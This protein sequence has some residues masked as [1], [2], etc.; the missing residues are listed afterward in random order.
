ML[1]TED[2]E[3]YP[4]I[5]TFEYD[6]EAREMVIRFVYDIPEDKKRK[7]AEENY[8]AIQKWILSLRDAELIALLAPIP[9][10][11]GKETTT[12]LEKHL[13]GYVAKNTFDYF[14]HKDLRGFLT[15]EPSF[16][17]STRQIRI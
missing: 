13:K 4:G 5:K 12:L 7:Y 3:N 1:F 2:E 6:A 8:D 11:K 16:A 9:T 15:R 17:V 14:I 10:G